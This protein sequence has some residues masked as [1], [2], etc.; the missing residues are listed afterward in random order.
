MVHKLQDGQRL[1]VP[2][3]TLCRELGV[4]R[5]TIKNWVDQGCPQESRGWYDLFAV[6]R[7]RGYIGNSK[8]VSK[9]ELEAASLNEKKMLAD[10]RYKEA[11]AELTEYKNA[12]NAGLYIPREVVESELSRFFVMLKTAL[13]SLPRRIGTRLASQIDP[14]E[15]RKIEAEVKQTIDKSLNQFVDKIEA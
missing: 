11:Q 6:L 8:P 1:L 3:K 7:W 4:T 14:A 15:A 12:I 13:R 2:T 5:V 10:V 9:N